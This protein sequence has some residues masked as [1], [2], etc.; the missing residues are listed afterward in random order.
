MS[1]NVDLTTI[2]APASLSCSG[3]L[4]TDHDLARGSG[5]RA[6]FSFRGELFYP[7]EWINWVHLTLGIVVLA[8]AIARGRTLGPLRS[9]AHY[10]PAEQAP[11][12][13]SRAVSAQS[14]T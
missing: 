6:R 2:M 4:D 1:E 10:S 9:S 14:C 8:I 7:S 13:K 12:T 11:A 5:R 3:R